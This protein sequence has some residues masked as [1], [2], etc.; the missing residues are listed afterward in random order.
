MRAGR[1]VVLEISRVTKPSHSGSKGVTLTMMPQR[2]YVD[3]PTQMV[4]T[5]RGILKYS[6]ERASAKELGGTI[7]LGACTETKERSGVEGLGVDDGRVDVGED[8]ELLGY[9]D[10]VSV[11]GEPEGDHSLAYL[12]LAEG[13]DHL[14]FGSLLADPAVA[15][16]CHAVRH[17]PWFRRWS[18]L[19]PRREG[20]ASW[21]ARIRTLP[22]RQILRQQTRVDNRQPNS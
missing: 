18:G 11:R 12:L 8:L 7:T 16:D 9:P 4:R 1:G 6:I 10:V 20:G 15:F 19:L 3:F 17:F 22:D 13:F 21:E 5:S 14:V 2:A